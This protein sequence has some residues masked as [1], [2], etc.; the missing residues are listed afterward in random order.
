MFESQKFTDDEYSAYHDK[1]FSAYNESAILLNDKMLTMT[2]FRFRHKQLRDDLTKSAALNQLEIPYNMRRE[3]SVIIQPLKNFG[4][5]TLTYSRYYDTGREILLTNNP[6]WYDEYFQVHHSYEENNVSNSDIQY[7]K[8]NRTS[9]TYK[10]I[11]EKNRLSMIRYLTNYREIFTFSGDSSNEHLKSFYINNME[12][13]DAFILY[14]EERAETILSF[15]AKKQI[16]FSSNNKHLEKTIHQEHPSHYDLKNLAI[17]EMKTQQY[18]IKG[19]KIKISRRE[20]ECLALFHA[21]YTAKESAKLLGLSFRTIEKYFEVI[22]DKLNCLSKRDALKLLIADGF[23]Q[24]VLN[25][26]LVTATDNTVP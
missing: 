6:S 4:I 8:N 7:L 17:A 12:L 3:I 16:K 13:F 24:N 22:K 14:F 26:Y 15:Y 19:R 20:I 21:G 10:Q 11:D 2:F 25:Y 23:P 1:D 5:E 18:I 9:S